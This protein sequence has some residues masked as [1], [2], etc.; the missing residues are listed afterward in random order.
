MLYT[1]IFNATKWCIPY[2]EDYKEAMK[3]DYGSRNLDLDA[4]KPVET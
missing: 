2:S 3:W 4:T 1:Q